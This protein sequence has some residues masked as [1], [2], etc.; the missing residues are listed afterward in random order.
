[1]EFGLQTTS[2]YQPSVSVAACAQSKSSSEPPLHIISRMR[3]QLDIFALR[4]SISSSGVRS[5]DSHESRV[6]SLCVRESRHRLPHA[7]EAIERPRVEIR[8][9]DLARPASSRLRASNSAGAQMDC[10]N[11]A[12][13]ARQATELMSL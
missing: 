2:L 3:S 12:V 7:M 4:V 11:F 13:Q 6:R 9:S 1:M 8:A 10:Q 5:C